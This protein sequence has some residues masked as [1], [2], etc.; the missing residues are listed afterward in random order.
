[1]QFE[2][3]ITATAPWRDR[4]AL[5]SHPYEEVMLYENEDV[6]KEASQE[7]PIKDDDESQAQLLSHLATGKEGKAV[8][9]VETI[10]EDGSPIPQDMGP[11]W[12]PDP[13]VLK[14]NLY[15]QV[16]H[17]GLDAI[18]MS[19]PLPFAA[20]SALFLYLNGKVVLE[21]ENNILQDVIKII[22][23]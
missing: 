22:C 2:A 15:E 13:M 11:L 7:P 8:T 19:L 1:M 6:S 14:K 21:H 18:V 23:Q 3:R 5:Q 10:N 9:E 17:Y 20:L 4:M 12:S 16:Q